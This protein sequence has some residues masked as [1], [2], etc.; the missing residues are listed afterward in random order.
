MRLASG[1]ASKSFQEPRFAAL[2]EATFGPLVA[3]PA[4]D[5]SQPAS[6]FV[7]ADGHGRV[8]FINSV[9]QPFAGTAIGCG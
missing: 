8:G 4:A 5:L 3:R 7:F 2:L 6:D 9:S 1:A